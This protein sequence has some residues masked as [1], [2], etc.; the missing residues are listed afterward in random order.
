MSG[1]EVRPAGETDIDAIQ[2]IYADAVRHTAASFELE[3]PTVE[4]MRS[5]YRRLTDAGYP[6]LVGALD[7]RVAAY[8]YAGP[9]RDRAAYCRTVESSVYV[10][11]A[12]RRRGVARQLME[13]LIED[14]A[15]I[16]FRQMIAVVAG[17]PN[18]ASIA[19]H[20]SLGFECVGV[21]RDVGW[22]FDAWQDIC[23]MQRTLDP[24]P[25]HPPDS[26]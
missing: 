9:F 5:R 7:H 19:F 15:A 23:L 6:Y 16:G 13:R 20:E 26:G 4:D 18:A 25:A 21:L 17:K 3:P 8:C 2:R 1:L 14:C 11:D 10:A 22:K 24:A 12:H